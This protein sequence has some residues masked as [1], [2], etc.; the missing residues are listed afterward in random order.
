MR[1]RL[2]VAA[3][4][5][6]VAVTPAAH[7][8][9]PT[10]YSLAGGCWSLPGLGEKL[11][12]QATTLGE[13]LLYRPD[14]TFVAAD[15]TPA[16]APSAATEWVVDD[17][18][19]FTPKA[20]GP[21]RAV[22]PVPA[23]GCAVYPEAGLDATGTPSR[24]AT[25][26]QTVGGFLEGHMHWM[27]FQ[28]FGGEFHCGSPWHPYGVVHAFPDC[29]TVEGP[30]GTVAPMQNVLNYGNPVQPHDTTGWP[31]FTEWGPHNLSYE[32]TYWRWVQRAWMAGLRMMV[33]TLNE[34]RILCELQTRRRYPCDE[35]TTVRRDLHLVHDLQRY[36]DAQAGGPGKGFFQIVTDP[37]EARRVINSGRM[38]VVL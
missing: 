27:T 7:A 26:F 25:P 10:R 15:G 36:V 8:A 9:E 28:Y 24:G 12:L 14:G 16:P 11:R 31:A 21:T 5:A 4:T 34:N 19:R 23:D 3:A 35:M 37:Y 29:S 13:Y 17:A 1:G 33:L 20:G 6:V 2:V 22:T 30:Q 18:L 32:G 38:A